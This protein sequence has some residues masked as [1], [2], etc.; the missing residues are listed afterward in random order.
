MACSEVSTIL[1]DFTVSHDY[2]SP[3]TE[4]PILNDPSLLLF[5]RMNELSTKLLSSR[6]A[7]KD[8]VALN[9]GLDQV[10]RILSSGSLTQDEDGSWPYEG[11]GISGAAEALG[12]IHQHIE[13]PQVA[14]YSIDTTK[15]SEPAPRESPEEEPQVVPQI[16]RRMSQLRRR[17]TE[18][19]VFIF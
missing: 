14:F 15:M 18:M 16:I 9:R 17:Q 4:N 10:E 8:I 2:T 11:L 12:R 3:T 7:G 19:K 6:P 1:P 13:Q 5:K